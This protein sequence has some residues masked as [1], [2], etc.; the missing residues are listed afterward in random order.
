MPFE[1][2]LKL[3]LIAIESKLSRVAREGRQAFDQNDFKGAQASLNL[4]TFLT[5]FKDHASEVLK[6]LAKDS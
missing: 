2:T 3:L 4:S 5:E 6:S 1:E